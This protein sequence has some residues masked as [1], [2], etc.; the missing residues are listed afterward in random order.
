M[1]VLER[2]GT[3]TQLA[4]SLL[5]AVAAS[6]F[7]YVAVSGGWSDDQA[8]PKP[9]PSAQVSAVAQ[10]SGPAK[11]KGQAIRTKL[12]VSVGADRSTVR[13]DGA[14]LG[15]TPLFTET[16]CRLGEPLQVLVIEPSGKTLTFAPTCVEG[17]VRVEP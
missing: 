8:P 3:G 16:S 4:G 7:L 6:R 11:P 1:N 14:T 12:L 10:G 15:K 2:L 17:T 9:A 5:L 13:V